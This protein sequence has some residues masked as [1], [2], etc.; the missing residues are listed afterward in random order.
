MKR[1]LKFMILSASITVGTVSFAQDKSV[2]IYG[3]DIA[4]LHQKDG[5][6]VYDLVLQKTAE[7]GVHFELSVL[8]LKRADKLLENCASCCITPANK[9]PDFY[10][11]GDDYITSDSMFVAKVFAWT[12]P[13]TPSIT[14]LDGLKGKKI[15]TRMGM[16]YG[17]NI[18]NAPLKFVEAPTIEANIKKLKHKRIDAFIAY[19][20]DAFTSFEDAGEKTYS[21]SP[22]H[23]LAAHEDQVICKKSPQT[24]NF[25]KSFNSA[26][27]VMRH[28]GTLKALVGEQN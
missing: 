24:E 23:P 18:D 7:Q 13:D 26:L 14:S 12:L 1:L 2:K 8:P 15:G 16:I 20:P 22:N 6:G 27:A 28:D 9:S 25:I 10:N 21:H 3:L 4:G 11:Y 5:Q 17:K 19:T